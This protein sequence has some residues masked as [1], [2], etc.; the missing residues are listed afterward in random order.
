M[1]IVAKSGLDENEA[2]DIIK[3]RTFKSSVDKDGKNPEHMVLLEFLLMYIIIT[4]VVGA[5]PIE[6]L[7]EFLN[8]FG[9]PK[10]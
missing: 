9:V 1:E 6:N 10:L 4:V 3:N 2:N 8:H 7:I 5:Q